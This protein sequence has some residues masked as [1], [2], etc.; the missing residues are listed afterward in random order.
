MIRESVELARPRDEVF[1]YVADFENLPAFCETSASVRKLTEGP[2]GRGTLFEQVFRLPVGRMRANVELVEFEAGR[3][4][5]YQS[6][7]GPRVRG[8]CAFTDIGSGR[9]RLEYT[10]ELRPRGGFRLLAPLFSLMLGR[11]TRA[12]LRKLRQLL[13]ERNVAA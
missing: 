10:V 1:R 6:D 13:G 4:F 11:Q 8:T 5:V 2:I 12:D 9:T 3:R 7:S